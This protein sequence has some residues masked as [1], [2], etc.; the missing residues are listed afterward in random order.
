M[1]ASTRRKQR[2]IDAKIKPMQK[3]LLA[4]FKGYAQILARQESSNVSK[5]K[6]LS[7]EEQVKQDEL[8]A[9]LMRYG[10]ATARDSALSVGNNTRGIKTLLGGKDASKII[11]S[12]ENKIVFF[13][14]L[15]GWYEAQAG[16]ILKSTKKMIRDSVDRLIADALAEVPTPSAGEIARRIRT[17]VAAVGKDGEM[18]GFSNERAMLIA[19]T[20]LVQAYNSGAYLGMK[21]LGIKKKQWIAQT[22]GKSGDRHHEWMNGK[23][24]DI[25]KP[26]KTWLGNELDYP[27][28]PFGPIKET[29]N[30][31]CDVV[32]VIFDKKGNIL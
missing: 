21:A 28:D 4:W 6:K 10:L 31:R 27:G 3:A 26:F 12:K 18:Y 11:L 23:V 13:Q 7:K 15:S 5:A 9:L 30:C 29:A 16:E 24:V 32:S 8:V 1:N 25:D 19:R 14:Q 22:D 17:Q 20:E 2:A